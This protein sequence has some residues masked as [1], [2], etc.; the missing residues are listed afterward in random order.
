M[1]TFSRALAAG[2]VL[3]LTL[4]LSAATVVAHGDAE[5]EADL[6]EGAATF[7]DGIATADAAL[8]SIVE[9][10]AGDVTVGYESRQTLTSADTA[11]DS[12]AA[13]P[14]SGMTLRCVGGDDDGRHACEEMG[15]VLDGSG[16]FACEVL[17]DAVVCGHLAHD[18]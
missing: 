15:E 7:H 2:T 4:T 8:A 11:D 18:G 17:D 10:L 3:A 5:S 12:A 16:H 14:E 1:T 6:V 13:A 9:S